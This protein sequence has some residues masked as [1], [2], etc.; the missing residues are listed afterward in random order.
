MSFI[1]EYG[2]KEKPGIMPS[3]PGLPLSFNVLQI[4]NL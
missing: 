3:P 4:C 1:C 2:Y